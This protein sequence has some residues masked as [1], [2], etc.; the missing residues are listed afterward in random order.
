MVL[1]KME[2]VER[3]ARGKV[4]RRRHRY[5]QTS[6]GFV[7]TTQGGDRGY[8][9]AAPRGSGHVVEK[10]A[11]ASAQPDADRLHRELDE[12]LERK[13]AEW[14]AREA[15][16]LKR[17]EALGGEV[18]DLKVR[19]TS[20]EDRPAQAMPKSLAGEL[21]LLRDRIAQL[22][23]A[24]DERLTSLEKTMAVLGNAAAAQLEG[25]G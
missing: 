7:E 18:G 14:R 2:V 9:D 21:T 19:V 1:K 15:E 5:V 10:S 24:S 25:R 3:N 17:I 16:L 23:A 20:L 12:R 4:I 8:G 6:Q 11:R 13:K 22:S